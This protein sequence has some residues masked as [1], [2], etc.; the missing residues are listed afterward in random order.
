SSR[1]AQSQAQRIKRHLQAPD[2]IRLY[3]C[4]IPYSGGKMTRFQ[5]AETATFFGREIGLLYIHAQLRYA[6]AMAIFGDAEAFWKAMRLANPVNI[7]ALLP[8]SSPRQANTYFSSS[9]ALFSDRYQA[10]EKYQDFLA[11]KIPVTGG[12]RIYSSGPGI[13]LR[14]WH[15][16]VQGIRFHFDHVE[17]DPVIPARLTPCTMK[18]SFGNAIVNITHHCPPL[19]ASTL[20]IN[21]ERIDARRH[22]DN[23]YRAGGFRV[24]RV[25]WNE[26]C[27]HGSVDI[28]LEG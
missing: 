12:W 16:Y 1:D 10:Q 24:P 22:E 15:D 28:E 14:L 9:D 25:Q 8:K 20:T 19:E 3:E 17:I 7:D 4:P 23:P 11:G 6:E 26:Y 18:F 2:G 13:W 27:E 5:R 21:G